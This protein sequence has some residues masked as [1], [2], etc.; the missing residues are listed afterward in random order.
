MELSRIMSIYENDIEELEEGKTYKCSNGQSW[1]G[2]NSK[3]QFKNEWGKDV[4][5]VVFFNNAKDEDFKKLRVEDIDEDDIMECDIYKY[6]EHRA[7]KD[8]ELKIIDFSDGRE[9]VGYIEITV[10][11]KGEIKI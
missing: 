8:L 1:S 7:L 2:E 9:D 3:E 4:E 5:V 6:D 11:Y 10:D